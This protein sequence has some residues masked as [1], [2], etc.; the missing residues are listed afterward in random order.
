[1]PK[2]LHIQVK[3]P[4]ARSHANYSPYNPTFSPGFEHQIYR[5]VQPKAFVV[6]ARGKLFDEIR[7]GL[8][9][10]V[11]SW[12]PVEDTVLISVKKGKYSHQQMTLAT[13]ACQWHTDELDS[14][15]HRNSCTIILP[16]IMILPSHPLP[17]N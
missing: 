7:S 15:Q 4:F 16:T 17:C 3:V 11:L 1:M 10:C 14:E 5:P 13:M 8:G 9:V 12:L 6:W 2:C